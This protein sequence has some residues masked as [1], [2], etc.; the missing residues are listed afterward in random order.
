MHLRSL[1]N[2]QH[3][4][5]NSV[6]WRVLVTVQVLVP[7]STHMENVGSHDKKWACHIE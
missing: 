7:Q 5:I 6:N 4:K 3:Y 2:Y 1:E